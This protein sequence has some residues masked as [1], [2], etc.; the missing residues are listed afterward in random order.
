M[1]IRSCLNCSKKQKNCNYNRPRCSE[2]VRLHLKCTYFRDS[3]L[4]YKFEDET[5]KFKIKVH[6]APIQDIESSVQINQESSVDQHENLVQ[7]NEGSVQLNEDSIGVSDNIIQLNEVISKDLSNEANTPIVF[8]RNRIPTFTIE[9]LSCYFLNNLIFTSKNQSFSFYNYIYIT[10]ASKHQFLLS[11]ILAWSSISLTLTRSKGDSVSGD[12]YFLDSIGW[13]NDSISGLFRWLQKKFGIKRYRKTTLDNLKLL[14]LYKEG[15]IELDT[16]D[17]DVLFSTIYFLLQF[18]IRRNKARIACSLLDFLGEVL[19]IFEENHLKLIGV[20]ARVATWLSIID[21][22]AS[23][24]NLNAGKFIDCMIRMG[25]VEAA[26]DSRSVI[27]NFYG[28]NYYLATEGSSESFHFPLLILLLQSVMLIRRISFGVFEE[29][30]DL[31]TAIDNFGSKIQH[32]ESILEPKSEPERIHNILKANKAMFYSLLILFAIKCKSSKPYSLTN[33]ANEIIRIAAGLRVG[34][35]EAP[36]TKIWPFP[37]LCAMVETSDPIYLWWCKEYFQSR[38]KIGD[39][40][41]LVGEL[42]EGLRSIQ[43][44][45]NERINILNFALEKFDIIL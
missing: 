45:T 24:F 32:Y 6:K 28:R 3:P 35:E 42:I 29:D 13:F 23:I 7:I 30:D 31:A 10:Y 8:E 14:L 27:E 19:S 22:K 33:Q 17:R 9:E 2:C 43:D 37:I 4:Q 38:T 44:I 5:K 12:D 11:S 39:G 16:S 1:S 26:D 15:I 40:Y 36:S 25:L 34:S 41:S 21:M 20:H 18:C